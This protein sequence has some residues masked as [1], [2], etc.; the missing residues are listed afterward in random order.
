MGMGSGV[1]R[2]WWLHARGLPGP[3]LTVTLCSTT[4]GPQKS[5]ETMPLSL[6]W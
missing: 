4:D 6:D 5:I 1:A 2:A 3:G